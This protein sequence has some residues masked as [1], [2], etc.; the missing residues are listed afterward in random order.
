MFLL[1]EKCVMKKFNKEIAENHINKLCRKHKI[2]ISPVRFKSSCGRAW[3]NTRV[4][5]IPH[6]KNV[7]TFAV[8]L[9]EIY[10]IIRGKKGKVYEMEYYCDL[11]AL[12]TLEKFGYNTNDWIKRM[13]WHSL[14]C[15]AKAHNRRANM[16]NIRPE[17]KRH[18]LNVDFSLWNGKSVRIHYNK[19]NDIGYE[20]QYITTIT[21]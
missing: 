10:H 19:N 16:S 5:K 18:F 3:Y 11:F 2:T 13:N 20:I 17:I 7:D 1:L 9:H 12:K 21:I 14:R 15:L 4:I 6:I 8:A